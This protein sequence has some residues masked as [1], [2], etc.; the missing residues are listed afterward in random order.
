MP[1]K[2][3][4]ILR[5]SGVP[6]NFDTHQRSVSLFYDID[7]DD[8]LEIVLVG[9]KSKL[10]SASSIV[11]AVVSKGLDC[12]LSIRQF[13]KPRGYSNKA[14]FKLYITTML[15]LNQWLV[16]FITLSSDFNGDGRKDLV[17]KRAPTQYNIYLSSSTSPFYDREPKLQLEVPAEGRMFIE[18]L[19]SDGIS[20][21]YVINYEKGKIAIFLSK[22]WEAKGALR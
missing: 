16:D 5:C 12:T 7:N 13:K 8:Y 20:D 18:D 21:I 3:N 22:S 1:E 19:N 2:P 15:P 11:E 6:I 17:V 14:D 9:L 10:I 4:Q